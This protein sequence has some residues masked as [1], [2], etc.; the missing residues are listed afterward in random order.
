MALSLTELCAMAGDQ[1]E[2]QLAEGPVTVHRMA[3]TSAPMNP[4]TLER[5]TSSESASVTAAIGPE[6]RITMDE[7]KGYRVIKA[8]GIRTGSIGF[9]LSN[10]NEI[11]ESNGRRWRVFKV[12]Q[13]MAGA[14]VQATGELIA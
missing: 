8:F 7:G 11:E 3:P 6:T 1:V 13:T 5:A 4:L 9:T 10:K 12:E 2:S 14:M